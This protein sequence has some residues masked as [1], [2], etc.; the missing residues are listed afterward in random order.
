MTMCFVANGRNLLGLT[1]H[2]Q[3]LV[4]QQ[5]D[6]PQGW[7]LIYFFFALFLAGLRHHCLPCSV[8]PEFSLLDNGPW[9]R[10]N[11]T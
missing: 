10:G 3:H 9:H 6:G 5:F 11:L 8:V 1:T 4:G 7:F 2:C